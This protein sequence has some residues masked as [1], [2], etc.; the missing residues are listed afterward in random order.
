[1][2]HIRTAILGLAAL[3]VTA[4]GPLDAVTR[5]APYEATMPIVPVV[6]IATQDISEVPEVVSRSV[7]DISPMPAAPSYKVTGIQVDVPRSL[8]VSESNM[9]IPMGDIVWRGDLP[10][11]R[12]EQIQDILAIAIERGTSEMDGSQDIIVKVTVSRFH[13]LS[14]RARYSVGG[15]HSIYFDLELFDAATGI[16]IGETKSINASFDAYGGQ[17]AIQ[18]ELAGLTQKVRIIDHVANVIGAEVDPQHTTTFMA[19][20]SDL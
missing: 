14:Q 17:Q 20:V 10:G 12:Y 19:S 11:D 16:Q 8:R 1:M 3:A 6:S 2:L 4:C 18:A 15:N 5:T 9:L 13:S 7:A